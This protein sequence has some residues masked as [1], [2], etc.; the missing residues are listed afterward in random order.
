MKLVL[1]H[2]INQQ[3]RKQAELKAQWLR[4]LSEAMPEEAVLERASVEMPF[5]GK[6]L[7]DLME[8]GAK[9]NAVEQG[10]ETASAADELAFIS[11]ALEQVSMEAGLTARD[12]AL[13]QRTT[14]GGAV[15]QGG[16]MD[17][18][19]NAI[20]RLIE[21]VSPLHGRLL[22]PLV[23][24]AYAYL[25]RPGIAP[26][27]DMIVGQSLVP[28]VPTVVVAHS[29]GTVVT[30]RLMRAMAQAGKPMDCPL[31]VTLGS[32]LAVRAVSAALGAPFEIPQGVSRWINAVEPNDL[33]TLGKELD[34]SN[35]TG[36]IEPLEIKNKKTDSPHDVEGY[37][38][39]LRIASSIEMALR[40]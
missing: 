6:V 18:R 39:D 11:S 5:Y 28:A 12:I 23:R 8:G 21:K 7:Y 30:F 37:L 33:V 25:R 4:W 35:F 1:V 3:A 36:G 19:V 10:G 17:K 34:A 14:D 13:E 20:A 40:S 26:A 2:G 16:L 38:A 29:L 31:Y 9:T 24:Q 27:V 22:L 15:E 32:P